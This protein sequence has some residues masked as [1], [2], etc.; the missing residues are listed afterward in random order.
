[1]YRDALGIFSFVIKFFG[2][3]NTS[4]QNFAIRISSVKTVLK[5]LRKI[6]F[7]KFCIDVSSFY[8]FT[9]CDSHLS[10]ILRKS[11]DIVSNSSFCSF[12]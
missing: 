10:K 5:Y 7:F 1:M 4:A 3:T 11:Y 6:T 8:V 12:T 2:I 9:P